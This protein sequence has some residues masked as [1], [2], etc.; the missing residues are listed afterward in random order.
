MISCCFTV[1]FLF[2]LPSPRVVFDATGR[3]RFP[4][5][6]SAWT[7]VRN[8]YVSRF[9]HH[10]HTGDSFTSP[11][12][13]QQRSRWASTRTV[14]VLRLWRSS[15]PRRPTWSARTPREAN[16]SSPISRCRPRAKHPCPSWIRR[17]RRRHTE[18]VFSLNISIRCTPSRLAQPTVVP[19]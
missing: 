19:F 1:G 4:I 13:P 10:R 9:S 6:K 18:Y 3:A 15:R 7:I 8:H 14:R 11:A 17:L 5:T 16:S 2:S 12:G